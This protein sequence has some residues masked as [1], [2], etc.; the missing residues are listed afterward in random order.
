ML[1]SLAQPIMSTTW[2]AC[3]VTEGNPESATTIGAPGRRLR[4]SSTGLVSSVCIPSYALH[5]CVT[6][7]EGAF[8]QTPAGW[9]ML[10]TS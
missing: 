6:H 8:Q 3:M 2:L 5:R 1:G 4:R 9:L 7:E 10:R